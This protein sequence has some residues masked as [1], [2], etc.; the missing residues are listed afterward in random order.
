MC[1]IKIAR[2]QLGDAIFVFYYI[3]YISIMFMLFISICMLLIYS[4]CWITPLCSRCP[5]DFGQDAKGHSEWWQH[6][7]DEGEKEKRGTWGFT[8]TLK[9]QVLSERRRVMSIKLNHF[10]K[11]TKLCSSITLFLS[12][13]IGL[14]MM[15]VQ[16]D[17]SCY[18][19]HGVKSFR[20]LFFYVKSFLVVRNLE[21]IISLS[22]KASNW[23]T[24]M[25][26]NLNIC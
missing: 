8:A 9:L 15:S 26:L 18:L 23:C 5:H 25:L 24:F 21:F 1:S 20:F 4:A 11:K 12:T 7:N 3:Y 2:G 16:A 6:H 19:E 14:F 22:Q 10:H 17:G 13:C